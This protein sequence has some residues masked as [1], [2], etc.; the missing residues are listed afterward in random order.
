MTSRNVYSLFVFAVLFVC[1]SYFVPVDNWAVTSRVAPVYALVDEGVLNIDTYHLMTG[2]K[3]Y[4]ENHYYTDKSIGPSLF[5]VPVYAIYK[6]LATRPEFQQVPIDDP[7]H[8]A[9]SALYRSRALEWMTLVVVMLPSALLGVVVFRFAARF[10]RHDFYACILAL[11][12]GLATIAFTY[13]RML[14]QHQTTALG[15]FVGFFLL[16]KVIYEKADLRWLWGVGFFLSLAFISEYVVAIFGGLIFLWAVYK[17]R[18]RRAVFY[19][20]LGALPLLLVNSAYNL[21]AFHSPLPVGYSYSL[22]A[23]TVH[24]HGFMGISLPSLRVLG[25]I[26]FGSFRGL[27]FISPV[28]LLIIPGLYLMWREQ[29][30]YREVV[31]LISVIVIGFFLYNAGYLVWWGGWST[32]PR[33]LVPMLPFMMLPMA[34]VL[35]RWLRHKVGIGVIALLIAAST[36]NVWIQSIAFLGLSP[37]IVDVPAEIVNGATA[38]PEKMAAQAAYVVKTV[39][40]GGYIANPLF[41]FAIP[42]IQSNDIA[43]NVGRLYGLVG[44]QSLMILWIRLALIVIAAVFVWFL[45]RTRQHKA[46]MQPIKH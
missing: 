32:G 11:V 28:L 21:L 44:L 31:V 19:I 27:F 1:Y 22:W 6:A 38:S 45:T 40:N 10:T 8:P 43:L 17:L 34:F 4:F 18:N 20:I 24:E 7:A 42:H 16:W 3:A 12:Y 35:N 41:D 46:E 37:D 36:L 25:E 33:F 29:P 13:S 14:F 9:L 23:S 5:A 30:K 15:L 26:T 39:E 2:D